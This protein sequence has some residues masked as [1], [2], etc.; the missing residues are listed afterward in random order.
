MRE[1]H[2]YAHTHTHLLQTLPLKIIKI[3]W[4]FGEAQVLKRHR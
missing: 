4:D 1:R 3:F 2:V